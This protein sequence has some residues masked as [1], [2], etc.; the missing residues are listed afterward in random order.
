MANPKNMNF[1]SPHNFEFVIERLPDL[2][3]FIQ[4]ANIPDLILGQA[5]TGTPFSQIPIPGDQIIFGN[6]DV[7][8]KINED[9]SNW[10]ELYTW[11]RQIGFPESFEDRKI[12]DDSKP[13]YGLTSEASLIIRTNANNPNKKITFTGLFPVAIGGLQFSTQTTDVA[14]ITTSASF[15]Y[16][17][18]NISDV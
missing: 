7:T 4:D 16:G 5:V 15:R 6:L 13:G 1:L 10:E 18:Y 12:V 17:T 14:E 9:M 2:S 8:F 3:F 11:V